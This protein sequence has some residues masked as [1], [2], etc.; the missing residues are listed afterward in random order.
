MLGHE[1]NLARCRT[2]RI[3]DQMRLNQRLGRESAHQRTTGVIFS[4]DA[5]EDTARA[6]RGDVARH[7]ASAANRELVAFDCENRSRC[8]GRNARDFA[9]D[10]IVEHQIANADDSLLGNE[11]ECVFEI[12]HA[13]LPG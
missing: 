10:E 4:D 12:E 7:V 1:A 11:F 3:D 13:V 5:E 9:I 2:L 8:L 6:K